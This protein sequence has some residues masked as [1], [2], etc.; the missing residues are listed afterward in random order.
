MK[1]SVI[2]EGGRVEFENGDVT[3]IADLIREAGPLLNISANANLA[4]NGAPATPSTPLADG[5]EVTTTKPAG[6]K[7]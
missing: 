1:V 5:D 6:R 3:N 2:T 4:V 7:G